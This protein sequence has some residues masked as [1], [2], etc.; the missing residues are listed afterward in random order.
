MSRSEKRAKIRQ[1]LTEEYCRRTRSLS[2]ITSDGV[3]FNILD[4]FICPL[5]LSIINKENTDNITIEDVP[6]ESV[7]GQPILVT[8]AKCNND[9]G[10]K[11]DCYLHNELLVHHLLRHPENESFKTTYTLNGIQIKGRMRINTISGFLK[12]QFT[13]DANDRANF[14]LFTTELE[15]NWDGC[16]LLVESEITSTKRIDEYSNISVLKSAYLMAFSKMGYMYI[17]QDNLE[18]IREQIHNRDKNILDNSYLIG[19]GTDIM[20]NVNDGV[21]YALVNETRCVI[22]IMTLKLKRQ[23]AIS[24]RVVVALP[25]PYDKENPLYRNLSTTN[26]V[27]T[28]SNLVEAVSIAPRNIKVEEKF[29]DI[30]Y[31]YNE[32]ELV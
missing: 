14:P 5:C 3:S 2:F 20:P 13:I 9:L 18:K 23:D 31:E 15:N 24:L 6:P 26:S 4:A 25:H 27:K 11:V 29:D 1:Y 21:Y 16:N 12:Y 7:G 32:A 30:L 22:V 8:C 28:I 10:G 17:L 19:K